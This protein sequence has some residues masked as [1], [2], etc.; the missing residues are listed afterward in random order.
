M[1]RLLNALGRPDATPARDLA[2]PPTP[3]PDLTVGAWREHFTEAHHR[4]LERHHPDLFV[5]DLEAPL[6]PA[7]TY[8]PAPAAPAR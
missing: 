6:G 7:R 3:D 5:P 4:L 2:I 1:R 8:V